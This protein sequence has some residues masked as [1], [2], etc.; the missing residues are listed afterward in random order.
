MSMKHSARV[1]QRQL[2]LAAIVLCVAGALA[3]P[4]AHAQTAA[5]PADTKLDFTFGAQRAVS[6]PFDGVR[7]RSKTEAVLNVNYER[8]AWFAD[9]Q[10]G[11]GYYF[12]KRPELSLGLALNYQPGREE[13]KDARYKGLGD[14]SGAAEARLYGQWQPVPQVWTVY[15]DAGQ[16]F[17]GSKGLLYNVGTTV[18]FPIAGQFSG[19][20]D[21]YATGGSNKYVQAFYGVNPSQSAASGYAVSQPGGGVFLTGASLGVQWTVSPKTELVAS[22][23]RTHYTGNVGNGPVVQ[24]RNQPAAA[25]VLTYHYY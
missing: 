19:F 9:T 5:T 16:A 7:I 13:A 11:L 3:G 15:G 22:I 21:V 24:E 10:R 18:G 17:G 2:P 8:G 1:D 14:V 12:I 25:L 4:V 6:S 23:G 20:V